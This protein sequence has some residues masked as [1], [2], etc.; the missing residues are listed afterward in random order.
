MNISKKKIWMDLKE[1]SAPLKEYAAKYCDGSS[2]LAA[3]QLITIGLK[4]LESG[5]SNEQA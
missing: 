5:V 1:T 4:T 3:R 2:A